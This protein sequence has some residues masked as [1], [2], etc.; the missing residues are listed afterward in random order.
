MTPRP[1]SRA[2]AIA[3][4]AS[5]TVSMAAER[6]GMASEIDF[7]SRVAVLTVAGSTVGLGGN[8]Q[9]VVEGQTETDEFLRVGRAHRM[10][11]SVSSH[12]AALS[13]PETANL[14]DVAR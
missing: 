5:V 4:R 14:T 12:G 2:S 11:A 8:E 6:T 13:R 10:G 9:D 7:V 3:I 1:P